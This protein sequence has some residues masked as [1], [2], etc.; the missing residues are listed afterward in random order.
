MLSNVPFF[1]TLL[2]VVFVLANPNTT[3][4]DTETFV[5]VRVSKSGIVHLADMDTRRNTRRLTYLPAG[6]RLFVYARKYRHKGREWLL[7]LTDYGVYVYV[8]KDGTH[9]YNPEER[10]DMT[11]SSFAVIEQPRS[12]RPEGQDEDFSFGPSEVYQVLERA[13]IITPTTFSAG[14]RRSGLTV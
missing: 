14:R 8:L 5:G 3:F 2:V 12:A 7:A 13:L 11:S 4:G 6:K 1:A 10:D 9:Y